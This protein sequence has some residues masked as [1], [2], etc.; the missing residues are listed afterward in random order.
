MGCLR[1]PHG[2][3]TLGHFTTHVRLG[4]I[5][6]LLKV[7]VVSVPKSQAHIVLLTWHNFIY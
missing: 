2:R 7:A 3:G 4:V 5:N 6:K 1:E